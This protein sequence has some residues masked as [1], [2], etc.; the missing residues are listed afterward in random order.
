MC[1]VTGGAGFIGSH[2]V[3]A[4]VARRKQV[5]VLDNL[6]TGRLKNLERVDHPIE[7]VQGDIWDLDTCRKAMRGVRFVFHQ[8]ALASVPRSRDDPLST[9]A[10]NIQGTLNLLVAARD[11]GVKRF[12]FASSSSVYGDRPT[13]PKTETM[14][15][16][17]QSPYAVTKLAG[18]QLCRVFARAYGLSTISL[19]Y[20]N[21][22][23]PR[24]DQ[25]SSY[26]AVIP[27]FITHCLKSTLA[28]IFGDGA[29]SRD[30]TYL[31]DCAAANLLACELES[32]HG[33]VCNIGSGVRITIA[34]LYALIRRIVGAGLPP[35]FDRPRVG[36]VRHSLADISRSKAFLG[37]EPGV[38]L[39]T[40]LAQ[41]VA[42]VRT[43]EVVAIPV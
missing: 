5:R 36:D 3:H 14:T 39:E 2:L 1:L 17:P 11:E 15:P 43:A 38:S 24:H 35:Q 41:T 23:G 29:Q 34:D 31:T 33:E 8:A 32:C 21:V 9:N 25:D 4:L 19:R 16:D 40:G 37:Y 20:F 10:V 6:T 27:R 7:F 18:E 30:F 13:L 42:W 12:V 22:Y 26:A 28:T